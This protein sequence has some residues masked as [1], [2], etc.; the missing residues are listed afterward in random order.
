MGGNQY[1]LVIEN[2]PF[3]DGAIGI[4]S[5]NIMIYKGPYTF[6]VP[7]DDIVAYTDRPNIGDANANYR[8]CVYEYSTYSDIDD[9][10]GIG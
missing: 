7:A 10:D 1:T 5:G 3:V 4:G 2:L 6:P 9:I 8:L